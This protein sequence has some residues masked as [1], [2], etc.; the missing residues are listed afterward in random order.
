M[1]SDFVGGWSQ[2][3]ADNAE[4]FM[5]HFV[6]LITYAGCPVLWFSKLQTEFF[7]SNTKA[8]YIVS[9][10]AMCNIIPF[11]SLMKEILFIFDIN[12][13]KP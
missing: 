3:D 9:S 6:Q 7:L 13:P 8:E 2:A 1:D 12:L 4:N 11:M 10:Q 5:S